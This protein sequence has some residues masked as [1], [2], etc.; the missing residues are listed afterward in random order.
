MNAVWHTF[1]IT[2]CV[3]QTEQKLEAE[4]FIEVG[5]LSIDELLHNAKNDKMTDHAA[6]LLAY[7]ELLKIKEEK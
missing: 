7:D 4:E 3:R 2:G 5:L 6:V 1:L